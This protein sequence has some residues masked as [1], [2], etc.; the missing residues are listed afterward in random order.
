[1]D[2]YDELDETQTEKPA[3]TDRRGFF[4]TLKNWSAAVLA[5]IALGSSTAK[6]SRAGW[7]N[8]RGGG[9]WANA[10]GGGSWANS[11][12]PGGSW[13]NRRGA[14]GWLNGRR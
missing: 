6:E 2:A 9:G 12:G 5:G 11:P 4:R 13:V 7:L 10:R 14:G 8:S 3:P 1:M